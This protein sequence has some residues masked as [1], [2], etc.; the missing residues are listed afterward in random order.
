MDPRS[1]DSYRLN[2]SATLVLRGLQEG[3][4]PQLIAEALSRE[5]DVAYGSALSDVYEFTA[6]LNSQGFSA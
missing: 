5:F 3:R 1:G 2:E 6:M 4:S